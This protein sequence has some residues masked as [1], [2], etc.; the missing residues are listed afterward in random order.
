MSA[1][2][3]V[4]AGRAARRRIA[5]ARR[6]VVKAGTNV[7]M[8]TEGG[9]ALGRLYGLV[10]SAANLRKEGRDVLIVSSGAIGLGAQRLRLGAR[11]ADLSLKQACAAVGQSR[12]MSIYEEGFGTLGISTAQVLLTEEDFADPVR[13]GNLSATL[14][15]LFALGVV[16]I[17]NE[18]DVVSTAELETPGEDGGRKRLFG[19][20]DHLSALVM[21]HVKADVLVI[22]SDVDGLYT[23]NPARNRRARLIP[24][25]AGVT[26]E[27]ARHAD[28][29][30]VRG[31][32][33]MAT[34]LEAARLATEAGGLAV[35][36]NG[37]TP[38][39]LDRLFAGEEIG[40]LF[41]PAGRR[42]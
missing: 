29:P 17:L 7:V 27:V 3:S 42:R 34:K 41:L 22:L 4:R 20:N 18:N 28:G 19:D 10:E 30:G 40:T 12:L 6:I 36:A 5:S 9:V 31:R 11:P 33:G 15:R 35:V 14:G 39:V 37:K 1:P 25:V 32:G 16:P 2:A 38:H 24:F 13:F 8:R 23:G 26:A 21:R